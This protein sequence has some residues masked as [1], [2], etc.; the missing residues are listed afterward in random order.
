MSRICFRRYRG[1]GIVVLGL[2]LLV[3]GGSATALGRSDPGVIRQ[4]TPISDFV[5]PVA[6][7]AVVLTPFHPPATRHGTGHRGVD[8]AGRVGGQIRAT[9]SGT[10]V[11]AGPLAGRGVISIDHPIGLRTTYEPVTGSVKAGD[12]VVAG[13]V[14]GVLEAGHP[15]CAPAVCLHWGARLPDGS[16][17]DPMTLLGG[18]RVRLLPWD[19]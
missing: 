6:G 16:Y 5:L 7:P 1:L 12:A 4:R 9:G 17:L 19:R 14:I 15:V 8:L 3:G 10:V 11:F 2:V 13:Q 18:L